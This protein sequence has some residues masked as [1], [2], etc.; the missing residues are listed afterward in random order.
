MLG[1]QII[2]GELDALRESLRDS[3]QYL[4]WAGI[5]LWQSWHPRYPLHNWLRDREGT[6]PHHYM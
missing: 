3:V 6:T 5:Q 1:E 2:P 4:V